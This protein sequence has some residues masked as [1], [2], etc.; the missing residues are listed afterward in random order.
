MKKQNL[1]GAKGLCFVAAI[2]AALTFAL[3]ILSTL[4]RLIFR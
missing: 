4:I 3:Y 2:A 1:P